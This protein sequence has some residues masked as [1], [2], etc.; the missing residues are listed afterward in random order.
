MSEEFEPRMPQANLQ[1]WR[2]LLEAASESDEPYA[3]VPVES[4]ND[5][6]RYAATSSDVIHDAGLQDVVSSETDADVRRIGR[7]LRVVVD[8]EGE[9]K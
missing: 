2:V 1:H 8:G 4:L 5:L 3:R 7:H 9:P 6:L